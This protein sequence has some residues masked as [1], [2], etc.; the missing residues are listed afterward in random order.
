MAG[1]LALTFLG[2]SE[3]S[4]IT[5]AETPAF[6]K[7]LPGYVY[8]FPKD[9]AAHED[10]K[11]EW[12]Y[13]TGHLKSDSGEAYGYEL[14]FFRIG[15]RGNDRPTNTPWRTDQVYMTHFAFSNLQNQTFIHGQKLNRSAFQR[16]G[17]L[18]EGYNVWNENWSIKLIDGVHHLK[19]ALPD[20]QLTLQL[21]P[22]KPPV[23]H[24]YDG[25]SQKAACTGCASHY[26]SLTRLNTQGQLV[27]K[28]QTKKMTGTSWM[29][30]EFGSNQLAENQVGWD[31]FSIQLDN[32]MEL[33]LYQ[34]RQK[35]GTIEPLSSGTLVYPDGSTQHLELN[36]FQI[37]PTGRWTSP[38]S[39][40]VYPMG[41]QIEI[42][43]KALSLTV[44]P[45]F[46]NQELQNP[47]RQGLTYW[48]GASQV[49]GQ[50]QKTSVEGQAYVEM[51]GYAQAFQS[52]I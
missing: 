31:W 42:P 4:S 22:Q 36:T 20:V 48:E 41:W 37:K 34:L 21:T 46:K 38:D 47:Y 23:I 17:A 24:G 35:N 1:V 25:V 9:H 44:T 32:N 49:K 6:K 27:L 19:A 50:Y 39:D 52:D 12:W 33:M 30:Q 15:Q 51:T 5:G 28:G 8:Q 16:A 10:Y 13:Y 26:Y 29:D 3:I 2:L 40:G 14:T 45:A 43:S 11:T 7:A 18:T